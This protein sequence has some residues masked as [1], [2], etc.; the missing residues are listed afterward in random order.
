M[1][2]YLLAILLFISFPVAAQITSWPTYLFYDSQG[3][4]YTNVHSMSDLSSVFRNGLEMPW[5]YY[6]VDLE[7]VAFVCDNPDLKPDDGRIHVVFT[8]LSQDAPDGV[9]A[10]DYVKQIARYVEVGNS[11][12]K[13]TVD[14]PRTEDY[15]DWGWPESGLNDNDPETLPEFGDFW[16]GY[17]PG[18][19]LFQPFENGKPCSAIEIEFKYG[20]GLNNTAYNF[21]TDTI[22]LIFNSGHDFDGDGWGSYYETAL[23]SDDE[24][25]VSTPI[26]RDGDGVNNDSDAFPD[27]STETADSDGDGVGDNADAFPNDSTRSVM[28][29]PLMPTAVLFL[30]AGLLGF[31]GVRRLI[32]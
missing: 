2:R 24:N 5:T 21:A 16:V 15:L 6:T 10:G 23:G 32:L 11:V 8:S 27:D 30:L 25:S 19:E 20:F 14:D 1:S 28:P 22:T 13:Q 9:E 17:M 7:S 26:D 31:I 18:T 3:V 4:G 29:V 12:V